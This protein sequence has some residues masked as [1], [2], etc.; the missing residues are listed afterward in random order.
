MGGVEGVRDR[1]VHRWFKMDVTIH[2]GGAGE[3][4]HLEIA[5]Q[6]RPLGEFLNECRDFVIDR[7]VAAGLLMDEYAHERSAKGGLSPPP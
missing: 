7:L 2:I 1:F 6:S 3:L 5:G 4:H